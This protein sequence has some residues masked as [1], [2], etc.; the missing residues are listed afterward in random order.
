[1]YTPDVSHTDQTAFV[2]RY[3]KV[4][5]SEAQIKESFL[6]FFPMHGKTAE[7]ITNSI[8]NDI[9][10]NYL[11]VMMSRGQAYDNT[12]TVSGIHSRAQRKTKE[13]N[14]KALFV[15]CGNHSLSLAAVHAVGSSEVPNFLISFHSYFTKCDIIRSLKLLLHVVLCKELVNRL[16]CTFAVAFFSPQH[17]QRAFGFLHCEQRS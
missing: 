6:N 10:A 7:E 13:I 9:H 2:A 4:E 15:P 1:V 12:S 16:K 5:G 3:I 11:D 14:W 17:T 8:L